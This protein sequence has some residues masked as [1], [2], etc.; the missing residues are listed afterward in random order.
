MGGEDCGFG[1]SREHC[2]VSHV[3]KK[4]IGPGIKRERK[5]A[6][7]QSENEKNTKKLNQDKNKSRRG[8]SRE[9]ER[10]RSKE[11]SRRITWRRR[12]I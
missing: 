1:I 12:W 3:H 10:G 11:T 4:Q 5:G 6:N 7:K 9:R 2:T 8:R